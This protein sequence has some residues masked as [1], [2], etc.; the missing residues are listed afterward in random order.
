MFHEVKGSTFTLAAGDG[1]KVDIDLVEIAD[2]KETA[3]QQSFSLLFVVPDP[4]RVEQGLYDLDHPTL[5]QMQLF[6]VPV[7]LKDN[8][9]QMEAVFNL[10]REKVAKS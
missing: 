3:T 7:G 4:Y 10:L 8:R 6:L 9:L 1:Q 2:L 5:G